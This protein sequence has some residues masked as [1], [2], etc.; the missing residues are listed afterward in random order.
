MNKFYPSKT[1]KTV[2]T[3]RI[4]ADLLSEIDEL[5]GKVDISRNEFIMQCIDFAMNSSQIRKE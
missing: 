1:E 4:K 2:I 3:L 5:S